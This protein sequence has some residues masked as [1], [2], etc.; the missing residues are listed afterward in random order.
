[1]M[2]KVIKVDSV[3]LP[4][5]DVMSADIAREIMNDYFKKHKCEIDE[6]LKMI[7]STIR[8]KASQGYDSMSFELRDIHCPNNLKRCIIDTLNED[9]FKISYCMGKYTL[10]W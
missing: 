9:G 5:L 1:M 7:Y 3:A 2:K 10:E 8:V 6:I 4:V